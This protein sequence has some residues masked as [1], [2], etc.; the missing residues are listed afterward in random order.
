MKTSRGP[1]PHLGNERKMGFSFRCYSKEKPMS[2]KIRPIHFVRAFTKYAEG[3][4]LVSMGNT[5]VLC[6][7]S[8][9]EEVPSFLRGKG[10]GWVTAEY[11]MLP[12]STA[13]R[14]PR[15]AVKGKINGRTHEIQRLIG[16]SLRSI[17]DLKTLGERQILLDCDV[18]Q[19]DGGTRTAS[20]NGAYVALVDALTGLVK[21]KI[22]A[23]IPIKEPIAA[24]SVGIVDGKPVL[25]LCYEQDSNA[26]VDF[27]T[28][29]TA[30]GKFIEIQGTAEK[31]AFSRKQLD[32]LLELSENGINQVMKAQAK[33]LKK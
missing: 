7:A 27:N 21:K 13:E 15:E 6:T 2:A 9:S 23:Q 26:E 22:I 8:V 32:V 33:A 12:R 31:E 10:K 25:D 16:R 14:T 18:I 20:I 24:I 5:K 11:S 4:V 1:E 28:V 29:M 3:S 30:S 19:A 17:I